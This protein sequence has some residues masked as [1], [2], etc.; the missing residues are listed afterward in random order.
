[1]PT[2]RLTPDRPTHRWRQRLAAPLAATAAAL[3][4]LPAAPAMPAATPLAAQS[5]SDVTFVNGLALPGDLPDLS[6]DAGLAARLGFFSDLYYDRGRNEWWA[7]SDRGPGGGTLSYETRVH[8]F[9][10]DVDHNTGAISNFQLAQTIKFRAGGMAFNGL[11]PDPTSVLGNALDP[12]GF[13]VNPLNGH[14]L[15]ADEY[16][17]SMK[18]FDRNGNLVRTLATPANLVPRSAGGVANYATDA[19]NTLGRRSNRGFEGLAIS[20]DGRYAYATLQSA[21]LDEGAGNGTW[22]RIVKYDLVTGAPVAQFAYRLDTPD[23][24]RGLSALVALGNDRFLVLERNNRGIGVDDA[25]PAGAE[26]LVYLAD[27]SG[28]SDVSAITLPG[29]GS[30]PPVPGFQPVQKLAVAMDLGANTLPELGGRIPEKWEGLAIGPQLANGKFLVL[31]GTDNDY[32]VTQIA[33]SSTQ[34]DAYMLLGDANAARPWRNRIECVAGTTT[35]CRRFVNDVLQPGLVNVA[36]FQTD[37]NPNRRYRLLPGVLH[38][39]TANLPGLVPAVVPEPATVALLGGG[40]A[41]LGLVGARRRR[42]R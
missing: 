27:F 28:A 13:V 38:A 12:E 26:K 17:P 42:T 18:E 39:Y 11:A 14:L 32:S 5:I 30:A 10:L 3:L 2:P 9:T 24:S 36:D 1:M 33:G 37:P 6:G 34:Y 35:G 8:R 19:G 40:L 23:R 15:V 21:M 20:P 16:G 31:A 41:A 4:A 7:L 29:D 22:T 25:N